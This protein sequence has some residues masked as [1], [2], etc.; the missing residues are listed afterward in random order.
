[1]GLSPVVGK[2]D[3]ERSRRTQHERV[4][5]G[6]GGLTHQRATRPVDLSGGGPV[7]RPGA[8][9]RAL[10]AGRRLGDGRSARSHQLRGQLQRGAAARAAAGVDP[11]GG[12]PPRRLRPGRPRPRAGN[13]R[14]RRRDPLSHAE[15]LQPGVLERRPIRSSTWPAS[16]PTTIGS[17]STPPTPPST[18]GAWPCF[19]TSEWTRPSPS[20]IGP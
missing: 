4:A 17:P 18:S 3:R 19:P 15:G 11:L 5:V 14:R 8:P 16:G 6:L 20:S 1:M 9:N 7:C 2:L 10:R 13:R 12:R